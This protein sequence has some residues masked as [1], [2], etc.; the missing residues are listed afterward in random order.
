M[1][2]RFLCGKVLRYVGTFFIIMFIC[3]M[4]PRFMPGDLIE[5]ILGMDYY[6]LPQEEIDR[7]YREFGLDR[8]LPEQFLDYVRSVFTMNL[9]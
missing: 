6:S 7:M 1:N 4:I 3:F 5:N 9:G 2:H 8:S